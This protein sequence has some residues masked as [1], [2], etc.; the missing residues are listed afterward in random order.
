M[1]VKGILTRWD[2]ARGFGFVKAIEGGPEVFVHITAFPRHGRRP[3]VGE[4]VFYELG[5]GRA[6]KP[7]AIHIQRK[8]PSRGSPGSDG[9]N[10]GVKRG[11]RRSFMLV[12]LLLITT[13]GLAYRAFE[14][15]RDAEIPS[16]PVTAKPRA[17]DAQPEFRCDGR[18]RCPEMTSCEEA[19]FFIRN[20][21][22]TQM[23]GDRDGLP[24]E[25][26]FCGGR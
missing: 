26:Q 8:V 4:V 25:D 2:D 9:R 10:R 13:L 14:A 22:G 15:D 1:P 16:V 6:G 3:M 18:T 17:A 11:A 24:C 23:D 7:Q 21:P 20:C 19:L 12:P 5:S